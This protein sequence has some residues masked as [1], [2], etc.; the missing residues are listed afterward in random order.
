VKGK[1][2]VM[3]T[4]TCCSEEIDSVLIAVVSYCR[5]RTS[6]VVSIQTSQEFLVSLL[7]WSRDF[8]DDRSTA[9]HGNG[10]FS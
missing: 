8:S 6:H 2:D 5:P 4:R 10:V 7:A 1:K 9:K 3:E